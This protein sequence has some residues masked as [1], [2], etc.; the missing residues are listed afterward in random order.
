MNDAYRTIVSLATVLPLSITFAYLYA[1]DIARLL[2]NSSFYLQHFNCFKL[3]LILLVVC[4]N[5]CIGHLM[6]KKL[7]VSGDDLDIEDIRV[8]SF[9]ELGTDSILSYL[10]YVLPLFIGA[11]QTLDLGGW[12]LGLILLFLLSWISMTISFSPLLRIC[13]LRFYEVVLANGSA[14]T[15]LVGDPCLRPKKITTAVRMTESCYYGVK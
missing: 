5:V 8:C 15:L 1:C 14:A 9:K 4:L 10:P 6:V 12:I 13:G 2:P 3:C 11:G 7:Q